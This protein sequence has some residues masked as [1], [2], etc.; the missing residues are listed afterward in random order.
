MS[1]LY[2]ISKLVEHV[3]AFELNDYIISNA[4]EN[5]TQS[6][7]KLG[8]STETALL[9][10]KNDVHL[11]WL[12][13]RPTTIVLLDQSAAF[14][15][16]DHDIL[17][18]RLSSWFC[19][20]GIVLDWFKFSLIGCILSDAKKLLFGMSQGPV[21]TPMLYLICYSYSKVI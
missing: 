8:H 9:L 7:C 10:I 11:L 2:F 13:V 3:V 14:D 1:D 21:L 4:F 20:D 16:I 12:E 6:A 18:D 17:L 15:V 5:V 19:V